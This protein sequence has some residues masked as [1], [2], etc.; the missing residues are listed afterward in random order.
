MTTVSVL[1]YPGN[2]RGGGRPTR[3]LPH[4]KILLIPIIF[5]LYWVDY[6]LEGS[7]FSLGKCDF[8][9]MFQTEVM[10]HHRQTTLC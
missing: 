4:A 8:S 1:S 6:A 9:R 10:T 3:F 5:F 2:K 7:T